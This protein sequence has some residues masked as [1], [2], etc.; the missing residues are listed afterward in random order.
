MGSSITDPLDR[1][2]FCPQLKTIKNSGDEAEKYAIQYL[3]DNLKTRKVGDYRI[4]ANYNLATNTSGSAGTLEIDILL[5][6]R[7]G[8]FLLE[9]KNRVGSIV[10]F[11]DDWIQSQKH[12]MGNVF[13]T[14][15]TK[16]RILHSLTFGKNGTLKKIGNANVAGLIVL[17]QGRKQFQNRSHYDD[18]TVVELGDA[19]LEMISSERL[20]RYREMS[21]LTDE[22]I[23][24]VTNFLFASKSSEYAQHIGN[25]K[26]LD[27]IWA[28][29]LFDAYRAK[30]NNISGRDVRIKVYK[31]PR[32]S[33]DQNQL[34]HQFERD[35]EAITKLGVH[36]NILQT[37]DFFPDES[38]PDI[39]YEVTE[40]IDGSRLDEILIN[41]KKPYT[42]IEQINLLEPI[43]MGL[44]HAHTNKVFHRNL[45][46]ET[47]FISSKGIVKLADFDFAKIEGAMTIAIPGQV[48]IDTPY[49]AP[50]VK[51]DATLASYRSDI[52]S[53]GALWYQLASVPSPMI[54]TLSLDKVDILDIPIDAKLLMRQML[55]T[56][57][58][59]RPGSVQSI[60][61]QLRHI[62]EVMQ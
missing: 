58:G 54:S 51:N 29:D 17:F 23:I 22:E 34:V 7:F 19:L 59:L 36:P 11:D 61:E 28:G 42:F 35:I 40:L 56:K 27:E 15:E 53:L 52:F 9:V 60:L 8:L 32:L 50:E 46:S 37:F 43:C 45:G 38:R 49:T 33:S 48:L 31:L 6:N 62:K 21:Y 13:G 39:Y 18:T 47:I 12:S 24:S 16:S 3:V 1:V 10:A 5:I 44:I 2:I 14:L 20:W 25:Y 26:V 30:H 55:S 41:R 57:P 4:L